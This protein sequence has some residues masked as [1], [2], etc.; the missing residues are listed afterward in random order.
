MGVW[1]QCFYLLKRNAWIKWRNRRQSI[2]ELLWPVYF[3]AILALIRLSVKPETLDEISS[4]PTQTADADFAGDGDVVYVGYHPHDTQHQRVMNDVR[5]SLTRFSKQEF[6]FIPASSP[7]AL[8]T[9]YNSKN[10]SIGVIFGN[11]SL[12]N[13]TI[14]VAPN[15]IADTN[16]LT[17]EQTACRKSNLSDYSIYATQ[18]NCPAYSYITSGFTALQVSIDMAIISVASNQSLSSVDTIV[19]TEMF[20]KN[21]YPP[22]I[23]YLQT[24]VPLYLVLAFS[25]LVNFLVVNLVTEKEKKIKEGMKMMGLSDI[26]FWLSWFITY[27]IIM[28]FTVLITSVISALAILRNSQFFIIFLMYF[29]Y[30]FS[31]I[32]FSFM[33]TPFFKKAVV[34]GAIGSF[35][36]VIFS[37]LALLAVYLD[38][39]SQVQWIL[40]LLSPAAFGFG[41]VQVIADLILMTGRVVVVC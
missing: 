29:G 9:L 35:A 18:F 21:E 8:T 5:T 31:V 3:V 15:L 27:G 34:A 24:I 28:L 30:G 10:I 16:K 39:S 12:N 26:A 38:V 37:V 41:I 23:Q 4:F 7:D 20:P 13:Y 2:H 19:D 1:Q 33:L 32:S 17:T 6:G 22:N 36:S 40:S 25:P 14:R 11:D